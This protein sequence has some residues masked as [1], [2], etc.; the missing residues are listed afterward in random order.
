MELFRD[1]QIIHRVG[2]VPRFLRIAPL[3]HI[4]VLH[5]ANI[6]LEFT[7]FEVKMRVQEGPA[8]LASQHGEAGV[9]HSRDFLLSLVKIGQRAEDE[10]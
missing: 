5:L 3:A 1:Y 2:L 10:G 9:I 4:S 8:S 6:A 7:P